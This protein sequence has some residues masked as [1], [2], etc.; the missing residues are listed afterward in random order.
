MNGSNDR[1]A[2]DTV[3]ADPDT[4]SSYLQ[5]LESVSRTS[6][7]LQ[8][9]TFTAG[10]FGVLDLNANKTSS[11]SLES[12]SQTTDEPQPGDVVLEELQVGHLMPN[13]EGTVDP[14]SV[15]FPEFNS[16]FEVNNALD[17]NDLFGP[18]FDL[19]DPLSTWQMT[20]A[21]DPLQLL[22]MAA[23]QSA[24]YGQN[25]GSQF[26][27]SDMASPTIHI[28]P[29]TTGLISTTAASNEAMES[30]LATAM[31]ELLKYFK[32]NIVPQW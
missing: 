27:I 22:A 12:S 2:S 7:G 23:D 18:N 30:V 20:A 6:A 26:L 25:Y 16:I 3:H 29:H 10:P 13:A 19:T 14:P 32:E 4:V 17:W 15:G 11:S 1:L 8:Q 31:P 9:G 28:S 21:D 5:E 24:D